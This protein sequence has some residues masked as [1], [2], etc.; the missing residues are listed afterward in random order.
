MS[1]SESG[2]KISYSVITTLMELTVTV[3]D[4]P[5]VLSMFIKVGLY[6]HKEGWIQGRWIAKMNTIGVDEEVM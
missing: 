4:C 2:Y 3:Y 1:Q 5:V 6:I